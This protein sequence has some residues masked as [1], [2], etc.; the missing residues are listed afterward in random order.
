MSQLSIDKVAKHLLLNEP[1]R[2][3][4]YQYVQEKLNNVLIRKVYNKYEII[5]EIG[6]ILKD[7]NKIFPEY[8]GSFDINPTSKNC[9]SIALNSED[10][11]GVL[12]F[13]VSTGG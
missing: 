4:I 13:E 2:E 9:Y 3:I 5:W 11:Y 12:E 8:T 10:E 7:I 1:Q 6:E